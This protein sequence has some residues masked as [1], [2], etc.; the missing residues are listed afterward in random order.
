MKDNEL[1]ISADGIK[2]AVCSQWG[3]SNITKYVEL[4]KRL[5][6]SV[7]TSDETVLPAQK[8]DLKDNIIECFLTRNASAKGEFNITD[9][10]LTVLKGS[11]INSKHLPGVSP[12]NKV[13]RENQIAEFASYKGDLLVV[14]KNVV[15]KS[16]SGAAQFCIGG[17]SD[18]WRDWKDK[19]NNKLD[20]Y[21]KNI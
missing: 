15:F 7:T 11:I 21:R 1:L 16:P 6:Y 8:E 14:I 12:R 13:K 17:S 10:S 9:Q 20:I 2:F 19:K 3:K 18:G 4:A 5:G